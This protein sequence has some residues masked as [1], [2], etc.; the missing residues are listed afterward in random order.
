MSNHPNRNWRKSWRLQPNQADE[1]VSWHETLKQY[2][3]IRGWTVRMLAKALCHPYEE[4][5]SWY[6][7]QTIPPAFLLL[8]L[9]ALE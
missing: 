5:L 2:I 4:V 3:R 7:E 1:I 6:G 8:A 9:S